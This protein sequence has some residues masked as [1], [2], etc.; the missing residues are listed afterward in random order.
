VVTYF[1]IV[2]GELVP[3]RLGQL[4]PI[5]VARTVAR[6]VQWLAS[7]TRSIV[8]I[9]SGSTDLV[10]RLLG[11]H[12][13]GNASVTQE[14]IHLILEEG[15]ESGVIEEHE[16]EMVRNVFRLDDRQIGSLMVPRGDIVYLDVLAP[17]EENARRIEHADIS[18]FPVVRGGDVSE[19]LGIVDVRGLLLRSLSGQ[20]FDLSAN[21]H[22]ALFVPKTLT[23][24]ELLERFRTS[25]VQLALVIDEYGELLGRVSLRNVM[26]AITGE[27]DLRSD[28]DVWAVMRDDGSWLLDGIIPIPELKDRLQLGAVPEEDRERY[29]TLSGMMMLLLGRLPRVGDK[30]SWEG[31]MFEI[32]DMDGKR[33][34]RVLA[35]RV[36]PESP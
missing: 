22:P 33:I 30:A 8:R 1:S 36:K 35:A 7:A 6:P 25:G 19:I 12:Q 15:T 11:V 31:W 23:G 34:D 27:I 26:E 18:Q 10:L 32:V 9:L 16:R 21:L 13:V 20:P 4:H 3:K 2:L 14:E 29:H 24:M 5:F 17:L 28:E